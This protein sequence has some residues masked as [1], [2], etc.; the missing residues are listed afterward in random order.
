[1]K[2]YNSKYSFLNSIHYLLK[3]NEIIPKSIDLEEFCDI[4][5]LKLD[6]SLIML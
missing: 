2:E 4:Q 1:M 5:N 3:N 6:I